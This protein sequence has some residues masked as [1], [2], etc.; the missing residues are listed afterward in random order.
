[1]GIFGM[2]W[3]V[4][5]KPKRGE[6]RRK[7]RFGLTVLLSTRRK[8]YRNGAAATSGGGFSE[9]GLG[10]WSLGQI[11]PSACVSSKKKDKMKKGLPPFGAEPL[12]RLRPEPNRLTRPNTRMDPPR[13]VDQLCSPTL[14]T[15]LTNI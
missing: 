5:E 15:R 1:M 6:E 10:L 4:L 3:F 13:L 2:C 8:G 11:L 7:E 12:T 14:I 9:S